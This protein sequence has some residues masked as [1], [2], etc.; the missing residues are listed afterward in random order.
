MG[1]PRIGADPWTAEMVR[2]F[3]SDGNRYEVID[4][5]LLVTPSPA[6]DHQSVVSELCLRLRAWT[7]THGVGDTMV[8]PADI[9]LEPRS[10]VQPDLF[11]VRPND[12]GSKPRGWRDVTRLALAIE[13]LSPSSARDDRTRKRTL[14]ARVGVP[15]YWIVNTVDRVV[16]RWRPGDDLPELCN[17]TLSWHPEG[18]ADALVIDLPSLF[19]AALD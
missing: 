15:E 13:V 8:S 14:F 12:D 4:G 18:A 19:R 6:W 3:P 16:E 17:R 5:D 7:R 9:E 10:L 2:A 1:M 11:V